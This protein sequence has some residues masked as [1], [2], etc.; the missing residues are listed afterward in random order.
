MCRCRHQG[1]HLRRGGRR[2]PGLLRRIRRLTGARVAQQTLSGAAV[3]HRL[4]VLPG[5]H[6]IIWRTLGQ[7]HVPAPGIEVGRVRLYVFVRWAEPVRVENELVRRKEQ[8]AVRALDALG[9]RAVVTG[10]Q[11]RAPTAPGAL[12]VYFEREVLRQSTK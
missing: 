9:A 4:D 1:R 5:V 7:F 6:Y 12:V 8:A 2:G 11:K 3:E 10:G